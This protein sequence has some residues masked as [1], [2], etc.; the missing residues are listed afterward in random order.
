MQAA[1]SAAAGHGG[2]TVHQKCFALCRKGTRLL[3]AHVDELDVT[4][5][6]TGR[7]LVQRVP[8]DAVAMLD[9][10]RLQRLDDDLR[11]FL[12]HCDLRLGWGAMGWPASL[13]LTRGLRPS[14]PPN[15]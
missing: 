11:Y 12:A 7:K 1:R 2:Q 3:M 10:R 4:A 6:Q 14:H 5:T 13:R 8:H 15:G 9:T